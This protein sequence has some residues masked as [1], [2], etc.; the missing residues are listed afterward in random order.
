M[1]LGKTQKILAISA[2]PVLA[3]GW[4]LFRPELLF[5]N[6]KVNETAPNAATT[7][8]LKSGSFASYA[9]ETEGKAELL[10]EGSRRILRLSGFKTSNGPDVHVLF[11][12]NSD[13]KMLDNSVDLGS[14]KGNVGDQNYEVPA[15]ISTE[16]IKAATIWCKRFN[17]SFGGAPLEMSTKVS[18]LRFGS[19]A[20]F[21]EIKVTGGMIKGFGA[22][23]KGRADL[24]ENN[25]AR[26]LRL[27]GTD[28]S[29]K[30]LEIYLVKKETFKSSDS[31]AS[32][33]SVKLGS[34]MSGKKQEFG[35]SKS[36]D[37][38]LYRSVVLVDPAT[39][40]PVGAA[41]LRSAQEKGG[42]TLRFA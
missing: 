25:G 39:K 38:W 10:M 20:S 28:G 40:K 18:S 33:E 41:L 31:L 14:I 16:E 34:L 3:L 21:G 26:M 42:S 19:L 22:N 23:L 13:P 17:V 35:I 24:V 7:T 9:H 1:S 6:Q 37:V 4:A 8:V 11:V 27:T 2:V 30:N 29:P 32:L 12:K 36:L 5:V 15:N